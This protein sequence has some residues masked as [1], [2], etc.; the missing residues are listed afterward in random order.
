MGGS[1]S[2]STSK[3]VDITPQ[4]FKDLQ[5]PFA[6]VLSGL[7]DQY[8]SSAG[9]NLLGGYQGP[10]TTPVSGTETA[11]LAQLQNKTANPL[12]AGQYVKNINGASTTGAFS[13]NPNDPTL[14]AAITAAQRS[15]TEGLN[16]AL[17]RTLPSQFIQSGQQVQGQGSSAFDRAAALAYGQG[18]SAL[19]D[20]ATNM[21]YSNTNDAKN[22]EA[23]AIA[24][25]PS[26]QTSDVNNMISN[27]NAQALP[28]LI[29]DLGVERGMEVYNNNINSILAGLGIAAGTTRPVIA[30]SSSSS[31]G[32]VN[33]K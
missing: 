26:I 3:P 4:S 11:D 9:S 15:T 10:T 13:A 2:K 19:G 7:L 22:R 23:T 16:T 20:I 17:G 8:G 5:A 21:Q 33:L 25:V 31:S 30:N 28:R 12:T 29:Q 1:S 6:G 18:A 14:Q 32:G 27:L 24:Q